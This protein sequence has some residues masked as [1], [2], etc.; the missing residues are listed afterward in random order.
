LQ[1]DALAVEFNRA[2]LEV[3]SDG[4]NE[5]RGEGV[6]AEAQQTAGFADARVAYEEQLDL[7][8]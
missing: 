4:G 8:E 1:L 3:N 2:D 5:G 6:F 7:E